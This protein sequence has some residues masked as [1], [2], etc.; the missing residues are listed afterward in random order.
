[1]NRENSDS[2][3]S[4]TDLLVG[5]ERQRFFGSIEVKLEAGRVVLIRKTET[6]KPLCD[7]RDHRGASNEST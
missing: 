7:C 6:L 1:M 4:V 2:L 5:L 3:Q